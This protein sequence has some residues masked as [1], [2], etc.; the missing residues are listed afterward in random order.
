MMDCMYAKCIPYITDCVMA[1]L[2]KLG[3]NFRIA[4]RIAKDIRFERLPC[5]HKGTYADDC[6]VQRVTQHKCYIVATCDKDLRKRIR[7]IVGVPIMSIQAH[8]FTIE[9]M[10]DALGAPKT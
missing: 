10:P 9:R 8:R 3:Q 4:L 6:I 5:M 7:K 1:E 2:E